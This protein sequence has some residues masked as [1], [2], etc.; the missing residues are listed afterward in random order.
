[1]PLWLILVIFVPAVL[2][3]GCDA[4]TTHKAKVNERGNERNIIHIDDSDPR[5]IAATAR[6]VPQPPISLRR[7]LRRPTQTGFSVKMPVS[8]G[9]TTEYMWIS[10]L[11]LDGL[12]S[13]FSPAVKWTL[14]GSVRQ[15]RRAS[16]PRVRRESIASNRLRVEND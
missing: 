12:H 10:E 13:G 9:K 5:M 1:M 15:R 2:A 16:L 14:I 11:S 6:H 3:A 8:D 4:E 7:S